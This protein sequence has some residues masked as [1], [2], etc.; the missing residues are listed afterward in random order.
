MRQ[1]TTTIDVLDVYLEVVNAA[2][3][4]TGRTPEISIKRI[5]DGFWWNQAGLTWQAGV[6]A[7]NMAAVDAVSMPGLYQFAVGQAYLTS[8]GSEGYLAMV[9][10]APQDIL[11]YVHITVV[12]SAESNATEL[13]DT[14]PAPTTQGLGV[15]SILRALAHGFLGGVIDDTS[16]ATYSYMTTTTGHATRFYLSN[17]TANSLTNSLQSFDASELSGVL[18]RTGGPNATFR[19]KVID[20][21]TNYV[22]LALMDNSSVAVVSGDELY[23]TYNPKESASA[24]TIADIF[25]APLA[26][27]ST[28]G[29]FGDHIKRILR[30]RQENMRVVYTAWSSH[31][32]PTAGFIL[33]YDSLADKN[34]D[35][36]PWA[37]ATGR[38]DFTQ[39]FDGSLQPTS[40]ESGRTV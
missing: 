38:Y 5:S 35:V 2:T 24:F 20:V 27:Y 39:A 40:Y 31:K 16:G 15:G 8:A 14:D 34:A 21:Q 17:L 33:L 29:S 1:Q 37:L 22:E 36:D 4:I 13:L 28:V 30:L 6:T 10:D 23:L 19:I 11:E 18:L 12:P 9:S 26:A 3:G 7:T 25:N 32:Q